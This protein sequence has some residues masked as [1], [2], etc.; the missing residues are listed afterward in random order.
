MFQPN[1]YG[2]VRFTD[3]SFGIYNN[4]KFTNIRDELCVVKHN[5]SKY[6][7]IIIAWDGK[8][9]YFILRFLR[10]F[11]NVVNRTFC[12]GISEVLIIISI[13]IE[14]MIFKFQIGILMPKYLKII[15]FSLIMRNCKFF[16]RSF[17]CLEHL[18]DTKNNQFL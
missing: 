3:N 4:K 1:M 14:H 18:F 16:M 6:E 17:P 15:I 11:L 2:L 8:D 13:I 12:H 7:A 9:H 5:G 10:Y